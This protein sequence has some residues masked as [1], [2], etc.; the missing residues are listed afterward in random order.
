MR[1]D[2][3]V[4]DLLSTN[5]TFLNERLAKHYGVP[6][7]YGERFRRVSLGADRNRGGL[8]RQ[9]SILTVTSYATRTSPVIRGKWVLENF[10][11]TP[12]PP[13][14]GNVGSLEDNVVAASLPMRE[15][16]AAHR[17]N[18][19]CASCHRMIDP[20]GFSLEQFDAVG[21]WRTM[22]EG[23]AVDA[24][25][26]LP[27]G[28][29]F[30]GVSGLEQALLNHPE[31]FVRTLAEKLFTFALGRAPEMSDA[32]AI[33]KI[34]RDAQANG[35]RFSSLVMGLATSTPFQMRRAQ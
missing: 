18:A 16:L 35:Y 15:R 22:E 13:P 30:V 28:S 19:A 14:P 1:D 8:L 29:E 12:P 3:S 34:V 4:L 9:G 11:G 26:G 25:G 23:R 33:R 5:D 21:K 6:H 31:L 24:A 32:P 27:D 20:V 2:R 7:I 17:T 10:L